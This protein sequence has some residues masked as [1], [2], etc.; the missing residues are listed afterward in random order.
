MG[1]PLW[2][3]GSPFELFVSHIIA[4]GTQPKMIRVYTRRIIARVHDFVTNW[5]WPI[6]Q[7]PSEPMSVNGLSMNVNYSV[8]PYGF[9]SASYPNPAPDIIDLNV[10]HVR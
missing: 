3:T 9:N 7:Y 5:D 4:M 2:P 10:R 8:P 6:K 1:L